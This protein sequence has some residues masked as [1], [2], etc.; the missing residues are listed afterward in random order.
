MLEKVRNT[1]NSDRDKRS[2]DEQDAITAA[3]VNVLEVDASRS[4]VDR[5]LIFKLGAMK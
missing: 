4:E 5:A 3:F 1:F 2:Q